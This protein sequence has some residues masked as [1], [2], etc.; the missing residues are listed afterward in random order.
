MLEST[1][2]DQKA[3]TIL[4]VLAGV[5]PLSIYELALHTGLR[6]EQVGFGMRQLLMSHLAIIEGRDGVGLRMIYAATDDAYE[7]VRA[8]AILDG[9][10]PPPFYKRPTVG[11]EDAAFLW[12]CGIRVDES[13]QQHAAS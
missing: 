13:E 3:V 11:I 5:G 7:F 8:V 2:I 10:V 1:T 6:E 4:R 9:T 12:A